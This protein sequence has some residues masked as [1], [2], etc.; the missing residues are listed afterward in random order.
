MKQNSSYWS[1]PF[2]LIIL[3]WFCAPPLDAEDLPSL[4]PPV[5]SVGDWWV[6]DCQVY[7]SGDLVAGPTNPG[8]RPKQRW[9]FQVEGRD[10]IKGQKY[11]V[12]SIRPMEGNPWPYWFRFWFRDQDR[13][14]ARYELYH[15]TST[16]QRR[17]GPPVVRKDFSPEQAHPFLPSRFPSIPLTVPLFAT[18]EET[19]P[20]EASSQRSISFGLKRNPTAYTS[21]EFRTTQNVE[22]VDESD[23]KGKADPALLALTGKTLTGNN[24]RIRIGNETSTLEVQQYWNADLPWCVYG[25]RSDKAVLCK[26]YW[27]VDWRKE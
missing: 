6:V 4:T 26:K 1:F 22:S 14:A 19:L 10:T 20:V 15:P 11:F 17:I 9:R 5:W 18:N 7:D 3:T 27:L 21:S 23:I 2:V 24:L 8:W 16:K 13:Y 25:E 12:V